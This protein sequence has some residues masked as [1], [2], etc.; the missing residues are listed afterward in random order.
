MFPV[1]KIRIDGAVSEFQLVAESGNTVTRTFCGGC[2]SPLFGRNTG[3]DGMMTVC[4]GTLDDPDA[5]A[6]QVVVFARSRA[7]WDAL[8][9]TLPAFPA[10]P[11]WKPGDGP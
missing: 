9:P 4:V 2:G 10:Q 5:M 7:R 1:E 6:P 11:A 3:M 8:D